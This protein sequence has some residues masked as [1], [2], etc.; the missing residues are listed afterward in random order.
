MTPDFKTDIVILG[1]GIGGYEA[2]RGL[3]KLIKR[4]RL[5]KRI[6]LVDQNNYF[7]FTPLNH[8]VAA[9]AVEPTHAS[10]PLRE[11][12]YNTPH[13]FLKASVTSIDPKKRL[14]MTSAGMIAYDYCVVAMGS[15]T[16]FYGTSGAE[17]FSFHVRT[18]AGAM[19]FR[20]RLIEALENNKQ[21]SFN[22]SIVGGGYT[23]VEV[24]GQL[25]HFVNH[26]LRALYPDKKIA[27]R[28]IQTVG[29][30]V[31]QLPPKAQQKIV[32]RLKK[33]G[34]EILFNTRVKSVTETSL[35]TETETLPSDFTMWCAGFG[36]IA[37][38]FLDMN[39]C[40]TD[41]RIPTNNYLQH[42]NDSHLYAIGDIA[43]I[44]NPGETK[45]VPQLGEAAYHE[46]HY[47]AKHIVASIQGKVLQPFKFISR[48]S[49]MPIGERYGVGVF[50]GKV[51][52]GIVVWW[53]RRTVYVAFVPGV[54]R[55]LRIVID[56]TLRLFGFSYT[57]AIE[58]GFEHGPKNNQQ[59]T[60]NK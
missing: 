35:T 52:S 7:S 49:L 54:L 33:M 25:Q 53:L 17:Q 2:F 57:I 59:I 46:G 8:E 28:L 58:R 18:L 16:N 34:V 4:H 5:G 10:L 60:I 55:K 15:S 30:V 6:V 21:N 9:G 32:R 39:F 24:A 26:D 45:P 1:A 20:H 47:V 29:T 19:I 48:G 40:T 38:C 27:I 51:F 41:R 56:W 36:N 37:D 13:K 44:C 42:I 12:V 50:G 11:L 22:L 3:N 14:V 43:L 23:G 31:P